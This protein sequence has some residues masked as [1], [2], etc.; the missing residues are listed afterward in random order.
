MRATRAS[1]SSA[2]PV[3]SATRSRSPRASTSLA[4]EAVITM[5]GDLQHPPEVIPE[6]VARW[7]GGDE[8]V[9]A[10]MAERPGE[11]RFKAW[12]AR[13]FYRL[14]RAPGGDRDARRRRRLPARRPARARRGP[15]DARVEPLP[16][17]A[18]SAG[19]ASASRASPTSR[20]PNRGAA[21]S[22]AELRMFRLATDAVIGFSSRAAAP[23][24]EPR[25][26]RLASRR[27]SSGSSALLVRSSSAASSS[28]AGRRSWCSSASSAESS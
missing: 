16:A 6:L 28:P 9:Y 4:G 26:R 8:I 3:A 21:A 5:D 27:S 12:T 20:R 7:R 24:P 22:T 10:V 19:S 18:C 17:R 15:R 25:L 11:G 14:P 23:R 2:C 1:R 13:V